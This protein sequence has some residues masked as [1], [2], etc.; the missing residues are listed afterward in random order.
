MTQVSAT[1]V[2]K[3]VVEW[4]RTELDDAEITG[5]DNFLDVGGHSLVFSKLNEFLHGSFGVVLDQRTTY[6]EPLG[7]AVAAARPIDEPTTR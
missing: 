5:S 4:L 2:E 1:A 3:S 7:V 6:G